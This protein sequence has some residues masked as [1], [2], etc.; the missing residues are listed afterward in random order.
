MQ[1]QGDPEKKAKAD[2]VNQKIEQDK[3]K[4]QAE[5]QHE[6]MKLQ[7]EQ[8]QSQHEIQMAQME[9]W[10]QQIVNA[11]KIEMQ[12][13]ALALAEQKLQQTAAQA[14]KKNSQEPET[15]A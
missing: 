15:Y 7:T 5:M 9:A 14:K 8:V 10:T 13:V 2:A 3:Q 6:G 11:I 4:H 12:Q 1:S